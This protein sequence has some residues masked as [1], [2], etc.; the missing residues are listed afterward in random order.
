MSSPIDTVLSRLAPFKVCAT[1]PNRWRAQC[2]GHGG[3]NPSALS[4]GVGDNGG[5]LL[6]C[7]HGCAVDQVAD[8][9][10]LELQD[11]FP[12]RESHGS[13]QKRRR[14]LS[15]QQCLDVIEFETTLVATAASNLANGH[16]LT[17][18]DLDRLAVAAA[19]IQAL[20]TEVRA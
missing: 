2:P 20:S 15:A 3:S 12:P 17:T 13:P 6:K 9:L 10:G 7:F 1:G 16:P 5:V 4:V 19:R 11:L 8:A 18:D 14:L